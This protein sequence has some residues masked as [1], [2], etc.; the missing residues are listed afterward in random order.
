M[1]KSH[2]LNWSLLLFIQTGSRGPLTNNPPIQSGN[3]G[4]PPADS[5]FL[6]LLLSA[7]LLTIAFSLLYHAAR[8]QKWNT[9]GEEDAPNPK[10]L[11]GLAWGLF[12]STTLSWVLYIYSKRIGFYDEPNLIKYFIDNP[13]RLTPA[14]LLSSCLV[15]F[16]S[17]LKFAIVWSF[18]KSSSVEPSK[19][20]R[21]ASTVIVW[22]VFSA[23]S[24]AASI[25]TL[26]QFFIWL[27]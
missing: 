26:I 4:T 13:N 20:L 11:I 10:A 3:G 27:K 1:I 7:S 22:F 6:I 2:L 21:S 25:A 18:F 8:I 19:P 24:L 15:G 16:L 9:K 5:D 12:L 14:L 23:I 17:S